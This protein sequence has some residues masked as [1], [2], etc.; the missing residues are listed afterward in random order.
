[1]AIDII[2]KLRFLSASEG[3]RLQ[4]PPARPFACILEIDG[5]KFDCRVLLDRAE[6]TA[7]A[8][9]VTAP[10]VF[11]HPELAGPWLAEGRSFS[12][13]DHRRI[14]EG[15]ILQVLSPDAAATAH[16]R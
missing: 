16:T 3:G 13:R 12:L 5:R 7:S 1:M 4:P 14:A 6:R 9:S 15:E 2:V 11:L 10:V 8:G